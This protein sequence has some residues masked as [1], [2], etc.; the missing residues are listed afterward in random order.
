MD[1]NKKQSLMSR[2]LKP[3]S[4]VP[5][6]VSQLFPGASLEATES[7]R[8]A[9]EGANAAISAD[10]RVCYFSALVQQAKMLK[11]RAPK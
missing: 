2:F 4:V 9:T 10:L 5:D 6:G 1:S 8:V 3:R 11:L 7:D